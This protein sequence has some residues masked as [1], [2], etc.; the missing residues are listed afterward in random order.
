MTD[1]VPAAGLPPIIPLE[2]LFGNPTRSSP[3]ISPDGRGL[4]WIAPDERDVL[5]VW[6]QSSGEA[7]GRK[8]T[9]DPRRGIQYFFWG[10]DSRTL[11]Y[12]QDSDGDEN[13]HIYSVD[14]GSP[15]AEAIDRT[16]FPGAKVEGIWTEPTRPS[17]ILVGLNLRDR[18]LFDVHRIDLETGTIELDTENPGDVV[19]WEADGDLVIRA[20][21]AAA[22]G[23]GMDLRVRD[24][25]GG[26]W[27]TVIRWD[28]NDIIGSG[29]QGFAPDGRGLWLSNNQG[30]DTA[31]FTRLSLD[32]GSEVVIASDPDSDLRQTLIHPV[33]K[34]AQAACF[35]VNRYD[36]RAI[37]P[38]I[39]A[40]LSRAATVSHGNLEI[41]SRDRAD[42]IWILAFAPDD[43]PASWY[44]YERDTGKADLLFHS[45]AELVDAPLAPM[46]GIAI[47]ARDGMRI[48]V[49]L[50]LPL[51]VEPRGL[52]VVMNIHGGP[53]WRDEWGFHP[54][55]QWLANRGYAVCQVNF[56]GSTGFGKRYVNAGDKQWGGAMQ[57]DITDA[58]RRL[59][60]EGIADV[61]RIAIYGG[62]YGGYATLAGVTF[63]PDL[64]ACGVDIVGPSNLL[65]WL[66]SIPPYWEAYRDV[67]RRRVGDR[68][69]D[70][71]LLVARSPFFHVSQI[72]CPLLIAQGANDP[73]VPKPESDQIVEELRRAGRE[74]EYIVF[75]DEGHGF[76]RPESRLRFYEAAER[77][78]ARHLG[79]R[80]EG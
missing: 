26:P 14:I 64:Y 19:G 72:R 73:R 25:A 33:T 10:Q 55:V 28:A 12:A 20:A 48:H 79:G 54:E 66:D 7:S 9:A 37:D 61:K 41:V 35:G 74:V 68:D 44:R 77:F 24:S 40:D 65:T 53:W 69:A 43:G 56:R 11:F 63:T 5:Q 30:R 52:P 34:E 60:A 27:R 22:A 6:V 71:D 58:A 4:A 8:A 57:D 49:L 15:G 62:S 47:E 17:R 59:I 76:A 18:G 36:W 51:G 3:K 23:G 1:R 80:V 67:L 75:D 46:K 16:P 32:D 70:R 45:R 31:A 29:I 38:A 2:V 78:L 50:T 21:V 42:R 39:E 13:Y